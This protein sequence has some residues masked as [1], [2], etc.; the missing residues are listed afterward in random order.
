METGGSFAPHD[1]ET[2]VRRLAGLGAPV[3]GWC[4]PDHEVTELFTDAGARLTI[5][6]HSLAAA[7]FLDKPEPSKRRFFAKEPPEGAEFYVSLGDYDV[8]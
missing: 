6:D 1:I 7:W 5:R 4:S 8:D 2:L 3:V